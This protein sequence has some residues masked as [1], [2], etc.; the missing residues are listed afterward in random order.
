MS[1]KI[2]TTAVLASAFALASSANASSHQGKA[3]EMELEKCAGEYVTPGK[4]DCGSTDA[5]HTCSG[6]SKERRKEEW[7]YVPKGW[8][9]KLGGEVLKLDDSVTDPNNELDGMK[10]DMKKAMM[11]GKK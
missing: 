7:M 8:C 4:N 10:K 11:N 1:K 3:T 2:L 6:Q 5:L 9:D